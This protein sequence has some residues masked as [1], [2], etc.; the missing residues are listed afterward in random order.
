[1]SSSPAFLIPIPAFEQPKFRARRRLLSLFDGRFYFEDESGNV[2]AFVKRKALA[3]RDDIRVYTDESMTTE[4][5]LIKASDIIDFS[6]SFDVFDA[7]TQVKVGA[8]KRRGWKSLLRDEWI[9]M[10]AANIET[11]RVIEDSA[12]FAFLR[13]TIFNIVPQE[14]S[15]QVSGTSVGTVRQ[16]WNPFAPKL[17]ADFTAAPGLLDQRMIVALVALLGTV[18]GRQQTEVTVTSN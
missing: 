14:F 15:V 9:I 4:L 6:A 10:D 1:M 11:G 13:R 17:D 8:F 12:W 18:E 2:F 5:L 3:M 16:N 7:A